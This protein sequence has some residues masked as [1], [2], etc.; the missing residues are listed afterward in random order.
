MFLIPLAL[1]LFVIV[2]S[3]LVPKISR[4]MD[5]DGCLDGGGRYDY[6]ND[7]CVAD[8]HSGEEDT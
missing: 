3:L 6:E 7:R 4:Q 5:I 2:V 1:V 8:P